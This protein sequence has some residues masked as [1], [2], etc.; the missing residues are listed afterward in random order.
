MI[1]TLKEMIVRLKLNFPEEFGDEQKIYEEIMAETRRQA[2]RDKE[3]LDIIMSY[4]SREE[5]LRLLQVHL[6]YRVSYQPIE[7]D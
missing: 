3:A 1:I 5:R 2:H 6:N 4:P 7:K